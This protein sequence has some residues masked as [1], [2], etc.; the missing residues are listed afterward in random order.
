MVCVLQKEKTERFINKPKLYI[1]ITLV[2]LKMIP[3]IL[4]LKKL[5]HKDIARAQDIIIEEI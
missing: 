1:S 3:L 5:Q 2:N 4:R